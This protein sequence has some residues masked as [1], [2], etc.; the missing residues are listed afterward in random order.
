MLSKRRD[1]SSLTVAMQK[2]GGNSEASVTDYD[3]PYKKGQKRKDWPKNGILT[4][5][6]AVSLLSTR[7]DT[8]M[9]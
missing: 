9:T 3:I 2:N 7:A 6:V 4:G 1:C 5:K 8:D